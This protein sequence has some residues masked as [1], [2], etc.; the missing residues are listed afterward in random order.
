MNKKLMTFL[1]VLV[2]V[3]FIGYIIF[4]IIRPAGSK[5][6]TKAIEYVKPLPD[7]WK[8]SRELKVEEGALKAVSVSSTGRVFL[9]G[10]SFVNCYD[11]DMKLIWTIETPVPV[12][13]LYVSSDTLFASSMELLFIISP[14]GKIINEWGPYESNCII[15]S[16][17]AN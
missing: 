7:A 10:D 14:E 3:V 1:S 2:I 6:P 17:T 15:T 13:S 12:T 11:K 8:I 5:S 16:I 9:G 4:D